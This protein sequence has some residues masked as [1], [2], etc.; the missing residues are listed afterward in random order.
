[1]WLKKRHTSLFSGICREIR[2]N[3]ELSRKYPPSWWPDRFTV[4]E[5]HRH[6]LQK[7]FFCEWVIFFAKILANFNNFLEIFVFFSSMSIVF[8][9]LFRRDSNSNLV[10]SIL[11][12]KFDFDIAEKEPSKVSPASEWKPP[13]PSQKK[14]KKEKHRETRQRRANREKKRKKDSSWSSRSSSFK[15]FFQKKGKKEKHT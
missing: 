8:Q 12:A 7:D 6:F 14:K 15:E 9:S 2:T 4:D 3:F 1:M 13:F 10:L 5:I 11:L